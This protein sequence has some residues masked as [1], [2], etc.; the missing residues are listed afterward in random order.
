[1][2]GKL[3]YTLDKDILVKMTNRRLTFLVDDGNN[4]FT[5]IKTKDMTIHAMNKFSL[6]ELL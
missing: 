4:K 2:P 6:E 1:M 5:P 3:F